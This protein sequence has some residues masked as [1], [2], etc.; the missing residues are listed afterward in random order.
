MKAYPDKFQTIAIGNKSKSWDIRLNLDGNEIPCDTEVKLLGVTL[1]SA[2]LNF[3][4]HFSEI[5]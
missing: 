4:T 1:D 3:K 2:L 5:C